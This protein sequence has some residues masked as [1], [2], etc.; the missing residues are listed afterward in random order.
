MSERTAPA[1]QVDRP[2]ERAASVTGVLQRCA[3]GRRSGPSG[4]CVGCRRKRTLGLQPKLAV[5]GIDDRWERE[6]D[7]T[8]D[9]VMR[10]TTPSPPSPVGLPRI[11]RS[12]LEPGVSPDAGVHRVL[13]GGGHP[14]PPAPRAWM[15]ERF[16]HDFAGVRIHTGR[17]A[18]ASARSLQARAYT[19]G[20]DVVFGS[21]ESR[22][23]SP[24]GRRLLAHELTH[25]LQQTAGPRA[26]GERSP[27]SGAA[28]AQRANSADTRLPADQTEALTYAQAAKV[29]IDAA[30]TTLGA[31]STP[32]HR[33]V[34]GLVAQ[35]G[36]VLQALTPRH[37][38]SEG[39]GLLRFFPGQSNYVGSRVLPAD[40]THH[41]LRT[42]G[43]ASVRIRARDHANIDTM[44]PAADIQARL[45]R[46]VTEIGLLLA[47]GPGVPD[48]FVRYRAQF[49]TA[50]DV[51]PFAS[52]GT[53]YDPT[54]SS[55]GPRTPRSRQIFDHIYTADSTIKAAYDADTNDIR[56]RIDFYVGPDNL[57]AAA[58]P[59]LQALRAVFF[60]FAVP[61][62]SGSWSSFRSALQTAANNLETTD[63]EAVAASNEWQ[64][65]INDHV[66]D[67][68][69][70]R[71]VRTIIA[72]PPPAPSAP[73]ASPPSSAPSTTT[74]PATTGSGPTPQQFVDSVRL[75]GPTA[76]V[77]ANTQREQ[78]TLTP[79]S[80]VA[81]PS[82]AIDSR[83]TVTPASLVDG[84][85]VSSASPWG[86]GTSGTAFQPDLINSGTASITAHLDLVNGP[87]GLTPAAPIP[88]L[89]FSLQDN[90]QAHFL[91]QWFL[92]FT[93]NNGR[94]QKFFSSG[95]TVRYQGGTQTL[96]AQAFLPTP[97][98]NPGLP[99]SVQARLKRGSTSLLSPAA[100]SFPTGQDRSG[101]I[102][103]NISAPATVP[104]SGDVLDLEMDLLDGSGTVLA[105]KTMSIT[106]LP[107]LTY[108]KAQAET[109]AQA[110]N[111][112]LHDTSAGG[113]L[114]TM[115]GMGGVPAR[116]AQAIAPL[117]G[118]TPPPGSL[119]TLEP[120]TIR[121]DSAAFVT[122]KT[123][124]PDP[125]KVGY[126]RGG[127][128]AALPSPCT[129]AAPTPDS[130]A[131]VAGAAAFRTSHFGVP[132][133]IIVNRTS[134][135]ATGTQRPDSSLIT[136]IVHESVHAMDVRPSPNTLIERYKTEFRA[137]WMDGRFGP[138]RTATCPAP[139]TPTTNPC[140]SVS[141]TCFST[142]FR[143]DLPPPGPKS[144]RARKIFAD[145]LYG[146]T[147]YPFVKP[148]Y[149]D[150]T[151]G[152]REQVDSY[153]IPDGINLV[154][155]VRLE[156]LRALLAG[157]SGSGFAALKTQVE[158]FMG[159]GAA[160]PVG[161]L[162]AGEKNEIV[163]NRAWRDL[164]DRSF[165]NTG[166][167]AQITSVLGIST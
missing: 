111:L 42:S 41:V 40:T 149:D 91:T 31:S 55:K 156:S 122:C 107:E 135:V 141:P 6:A 104:S 34:A 159:T 3:C 123:G 118:T 90:R 62:G 162:D 155:S 38:S 11:H 26:V 30:L 70:R 37:D 127:S 23:A 14:L 10:G 49:D 126:F 153:L 33:N 95:D 136:L 96:E 77:L 161:A 119:I 63:R 75:D 54:L 5:G 56:E 72:T 18:A 80:T 51:A 147:T 145:Q 114:H 35:E 150:N 73:T 139:S 148:A 143:P 142:A 19:V 60:P 130:F 46:A 102:P 166:E 146:S 67:A 32:L 132:R 87:S 124:A 163:R 28:L 93:F 134:D 164:V 84:A 68:T 140:P 154:V 158:G 131:A 50:F 157:F 45:I 44:L 99:L 66:T 152:F 128:Y 144:C 58:S 29:Q 112:H 103:L 117:P 25:V 115:A 17:Q 86:A 116:V 121:H 47:S 53:A 48:T 59:R 78:V 120:L 98:T 101:V 1:I 57:N 85:N 27:A 4:E 61:I 137:Y 89:T 105:T 39:P 82:V 16:G 65:L 64:R 110:D 22:P 21:G 106:I 97:D 167:R 129:A 12:S 71:Q 81:N 133:H 74:P 100:I 7:R 138:P 109:A 13:A 165:S 36:I 2:A 9:Q 125:S 20:S 8:A 113:L 76:P 160:P 88:D 92:A 94:F 43:S 151:D 24:E 79:R 52:A 15:E 108:T 83:V 69:K